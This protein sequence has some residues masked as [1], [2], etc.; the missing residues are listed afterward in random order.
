MLLFQL[1]ISVNSDFKTNISKVI[2]RALTR[3]TKGHNSLTRVL[4]V[5]H[6]VQK[7][8]G[9]KGTSRDPTNA[10]TGQLCPEHSLQ[11][12][13]IASV[14][15]PSH[16]LGAAVS[17]DAF[18]NGAL[19]FL[20]NQDPSQSRP[21]VSAPFG[22]FNNAL[23]IQ[24]GFS[25]RQVSPGVNWGGGDWTTLERS[26][27]GGRRRKAEEEKVCFC[28]VFTH[29]LEKRRKKSPSPPSPPPPRTT[30]EHLITEWRSQPIQVYR[31]LH[32]S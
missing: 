10:A 28:C 11:V 4:A 7:K 29:L 26:R 9:R 23:Q 17:L 31:E 14:R 32:R 25:L 16:C 21:S 3:C 20:A 30:F 24:H 5:S 12:G 1:T 27:G 6:S 18:R 15:F 13:R 22:P 19:S 8:D 2:V